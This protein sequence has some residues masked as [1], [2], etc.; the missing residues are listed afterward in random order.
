[1]VYIWVRA[2]VDWE[3]ERA[4]LV[5]ASPDFRA[6]VEVWN[7]TFDIP[8]HVFRRRVREIAERN[9]GRVEGAVCAQ[10]GEIPDGGVVLPVDDDDWF[11]P[12]VARVAEDAL[13]S[14]AAACRWTSTFI[15]VPINL[16]HRLHL[17]RRRLLP[18]TP[19]KWICTTNN[20]AL[21]KSDE[22]KP[23]LLAHTHASR[24][25]MA[26]PG[27]VVS[28]ERRLSAMN[29]TLASQTSLGWD[30]ATVS[31][32]L[33]ERKFRS[34]KRLYREPPVPGLDWSRPYLGLMSELMDELR[35]ER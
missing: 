21:R 28:I 34:Y 16:G 19:P 35:L 18:W 25:V 20:Y 27:E 7:D 11:A 1:L 33:I 17:I 31:R 24:W 10:W 29:R 12:D 14:D 9:L 23:L 2:T 6:K 8:F 3:D 13:D 30:R 15:E 4:F 5:Q 32:S 26:H 22:A